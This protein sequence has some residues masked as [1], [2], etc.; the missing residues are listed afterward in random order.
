MKSLSDTSQWSRKARFTLVEVMLVM[1]FTGVALTAALGLITATMWGEKYIRHRYTAHTIATNRIEQLRSFPY[2][3]I[4]VMAE[5]N[6]PVDAQGK[7]DANGE[8]QRSTVIGSEFRSTRQVTVNVSS[9]WKES[10]PPQ[11]VSVVTII[12]DGTVMNP[13][14]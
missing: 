10:L 7:L 4:T 13:N 14:E 2:S 1:A 8:F 6:T 9:T 11:T 5:S 3:E 12:A